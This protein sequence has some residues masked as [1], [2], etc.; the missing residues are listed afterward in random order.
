MSTRF[1]PCCN[2]PPDP[3]DISPTPAAGWEKTT[4]ITRVSLLDHQSGIT[5]S[6]SIAS[7]GVANNDVAIVQL[8]SEPLPAQIVE[9]TLKGQFFADQVA[10]GDDFRSQIVVRVFSKDGT[11]V[12]GTLLDFDASALSSEWANNTATN[13]KF[14]L[15]ASSPATLTPVTLVDGDRIV[16]ELGY[17]SHSTSVSDG[18]IV[19]TEGIEAAEN[20]TETLSSAYGGWLEFSQ[21]FKVYPNRYLTRAT[22]NAGATLGTG[23]A[24]VGS[25]AIDIIPITS[26]WYSK[27]PLK[28]YGLTYRPVTVPSVDTTVEFLFQISIQSPA[29]VVTVVAQL[30]GSLRSDTGVGYY[31]SQPI[32]HL[33]ETFSLPIGW[34]LLVEF[35]SSVAFTVEAVKA[36][37]EEVG[38]SMVSA[39]RRVRRNPLLVR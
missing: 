33:P 37:Y 12:R 26:G 27:R 19:L 1:Y 6:Y 23:S 14:P 32:L 9:G 13:R 38:P 17:R 39:D 28:I 4:G 21:N 11:T 36:L 34:G 29:S 22:R 7:T 2:A 18:S 10:S 25:G 16:V 3:P 5:A 30:P 20:E 8:I 24:W 31:M 35:F 15:A